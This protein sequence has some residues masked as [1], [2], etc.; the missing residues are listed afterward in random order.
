[1]TSMGGEMHLNPTAV[2]SIPAADKVVKR[3]QPEVQ[4]SSGK[5]QVSNF[6]Q[7]NVNYVFFKL[8]NI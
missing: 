8:Q 5:F 6:T 1:M 7:N 2:V 4:P 3:V